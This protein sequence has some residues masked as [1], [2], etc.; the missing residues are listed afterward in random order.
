MTIIWNESLCL[1]V[2]AVENSGKMR[3]NQKHFTIY[4]AMLDQNNKHLYDKC[5]WLH[6]WALIFFFAIHDKI[7]IELKFGLY[8]KCSVK[9]KRQ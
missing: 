6:E 2:W 3:L 1:F 9:V 7:K 5:A 8:Q 4:T